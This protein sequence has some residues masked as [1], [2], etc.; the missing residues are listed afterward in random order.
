MHHVMYLRNSLAHDSKPSLAECVAG[1]TAMHLVVNAYCEGDTAVGE[2]AHVREVLLQI[3]WLEDGH[4]CVV[5]LSESDTVRL[6]TTRA[7]EEFQQCLGSQIVHWWGAPHKK[8]QL[9]MDVKKVVAV[10]SNGKAKDGKNPLLLSKKNATN[11][12]PWEAYR[13]WDWGKIKPLLE[14]VQVCIPLSCHPHDVF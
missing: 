9:P 2:L 12:G 8:P 5:H 11:N 3:S 4:A 7:L 10:L 13:G 6:S 14:A 1:V